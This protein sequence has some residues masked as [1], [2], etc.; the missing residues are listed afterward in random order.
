[1]QIAGSAAY[2]GLVDLPE[3]DLHIVS[4]T[5]ERPGAGPVFLEFR[6]DHRR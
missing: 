2:G 6:Y 3:S 4:L 1:M 5:V